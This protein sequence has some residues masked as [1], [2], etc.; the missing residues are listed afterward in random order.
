[1]SHEAR[2]SSGSRGVAFKANSLMTVQ[3][4]AVE[5][6]KLFII[7]HGTQMEHYAVPDLRSLCVDPGSDPG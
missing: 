2:P 6:I 4:V 3:R 5:F 1:M 7:H